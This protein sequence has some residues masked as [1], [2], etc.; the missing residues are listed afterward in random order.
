MLPLEPTDDLA[1]PAF[2]DAASGKK[3]LSQLQLTNL[4]LAHGT[5][6]AQ[7]D[8]LNRYPMRGKDRLHTLEAM[9]EP[10]NSMQADYAKR[11]LGKKLPLSDE[12]FTSLVAISNLWQS[13]LN[14]YLRC[15]QSREFGDSSVASD[16]ALLSH[17]CLLYSGLLITDFLRAGCEPDGKSWQNFHTIYAH[18][19]QQGLQQ[20][21]MADQLNRSGRDTSCLTLYA[22]TLL[23]HR[24]RLLGLRRNQWQ[25]AD[26]WLEAWGETITVEPRCSV[27]KGDAP[28]LAVDLASTRGLVPIQRATN[29]ATM[30]FLAMV[31]LSKLIRVKTILLQQGQSPQQNGLGDDIDSKDSVNLLNKLH[32]CWCEP[33]TESMVDEPR[34][35]PLAQLSVNLENIYA[36]I[37]RKPFKVTP[38]SSFADK[39]E[40]KQIETFGRVLD[41]TDR[42]NLKE[43]G[44]LV[45][46]WLVEE[47]GLLHA[48]LLRK[49]TT[50]ERLGLNQII[51]LYLPDSKAY[52]LGVVTLVSVTRSGNL[53]IGV[54]YLPGAPKAVSAQAGASGNLHSGTT[55]ALIL[56]EM[57][58]LR[59]PGSIV[60]PRD[61]FHTG[62]PL[63]LIS[64]DNAKLNVT[65]G[66]SVELGNDFERVSFAP[67]H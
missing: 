25:I 5:L 23:L 63:A 1:K 62:R 22:K 37:A 33:R 8:E 43:V 54:R 65:M 46:D 59:I 47:N 14:G 42:H 51:C 15:L 57:A 45:E 55:P 18:I 17:R 41:Q 64:Q 50:G 28:P 21:V 10:V 29:A 44:F 13:M 53:Y 2:T 52:K 4:S 6:R 66:I 9:R 19:E 11:L 24:A 31:P 67:A 39:E 56:P 40:Q 35:A 36:H 7:L 34:D 48:R 27:S 49:L 20:V 38:L 32:A 60:M 16:E 61:W 3:W 12:E 58:N 30:R 26:R